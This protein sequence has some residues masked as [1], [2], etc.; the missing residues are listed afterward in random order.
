MDYINLNNRRY[1][2]SKFKLLTEIEDIVKPYWNDIESVADIFAG[3]GVVGNLFL[4]KNKNVIFND[5]LLSNTIIYN[6]WFGKELFSEK[7]L[8][9]YIQE[10]NSVNPAKL[11]DN[12]FSDN[13]A[14]TY[15]SCNVCKKIGYI[16]EKIEIDFA[17]Q[18]VNEREKCLLISALIYSLDK[19]ANTV[20]HYDA[21]IDKNNDLEQNFT[22]YL[23]KTKTHKANVDIY[24]EDANKLVKQISP[25]LVYIDPPY[26]SR[27]YGDMYHLLENI[28]EW[29]KPKVLFKA[30]KMN[31]DH[32]KSIYSKQGANIAF[33]SLINN[34]NAKY[35]LV[36]YN[37]T[38]NKGNIRSQAKISDDEILT[39]LQKKG[40][41]KIFEKQYSIFNTG[42]SD[43]DDN[44][45]RFFFCIVNKK[46]SCNIPIK[47]TQNISNIAE[48]QFVK[49]AFNYTGGK[50]KLLPQL[51]KLIPLDNTN[52]TFID[53]F[54][55]GGNVGL[56]ATAE[57][58]ICND[59]EKPLI[60]IYNYLKK[61]D[62][63]KVEKNIMSLIVKYSL[64]HSSEF[65]YEYYNCNSSNGLGSYNK[66]KYLQLRDD[67]NQHN[68]SEEKDLML[69]LLIIFSFNNQIRFNSKS[70]FNMPVG[71]RDFNN[72]I[73]ENLFST[74]EKIQ[75]NNILFLSKDFSKINV[76]DYKN[77]FVYCDP[78]YSLTT[79]TYNE[80]G[81]WDKEDD[82]R[83][84]QFLDKINSKSIPFALSNVSTHHNVKNE[85]LINWAIEKKYSIH[86]LKHSYSNS[87][88]QKKANNKK[89]ESAEILITNYLAKDS[90]QID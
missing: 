15:F 86:S 16:R 54:C 50:Y 26:N 45:E 49:T 42:R 9:K 43:I 33:D 89:S 32:I 28:A 69:L 75:S 62:F 7:K 6:A 87:S 71:K 11:E 22:V 88:Y 2:G 46:K 18:K 1:L 47:K 68:V 3:T 70:E 55:G 25:D 79:A 64:S 21:F 83:L 12:Y 80:N 35:I 10:W 63:A 37:S 34:I 61:H 14:N 51:D 82:L 53:L 27:Q 74:I 73:R 19:I 65:G 81:S 90:L 5:I 13:F 57:T 29:K 59:I 30:K 77:P 38:G 67:Y 72:S 36:S 20:G 58:I 23:P 8:E 52:S 17:E 66:T 4:E 60:R 44:R 78:P 85:L 31:R 56:N 84:M 40:D 76:L 48:K 39:A 24:R 41:V